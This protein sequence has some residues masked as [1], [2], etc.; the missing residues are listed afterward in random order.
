METWRYQYSHDDETACFYLFNLSGQLCGYQQYRPFAPKTCKNDPKSGRYY[1]HV[2]NKIAVW[3]M[4]S[5]HY[6][7]DILC[8]TE[9]IFDACQLHRYGIPAIAVLANDPKQ[10]K[11]W[12]FCLPRRRIGFLDGDSAG[13]RLASV[14]DYTNAMPEGVDLGDT[15]DATIRAMLEELRL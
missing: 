14:C 1:T 6:R 12:L 3:G 10:L 13:L 5:F 2:K 7:T 15:D 11:P 8:I 9:G 4:E